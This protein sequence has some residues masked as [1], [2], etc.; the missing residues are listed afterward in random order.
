MKALLLLVLIVLPFSAR[1]QTF[2][3]GGT[4]IFDFQTT[5]STINVLL[6]QTTINMTNFGLET[7]CLNINHTWLADLTIELVAPDGTT[8][9]LASGVGGSDDFMTNTCFNTSASQSILVVTSPFTGTYKPTGSMGL[10]N[11]GQNPNGN[12][13]MKI[14]DSY[15]ADEGNLLNWSLTFGSSPAT[16]MTVTSSNLPIVVINTN[17]VNIPDEPK[18]DGIMGIIN[19]GPGNLNNINDPYNEFYG[20][21]AIEQRGSSSGSFPQRSYGLETR[22]PDPTINYNVSLFDWPSDNDWILYAP[23]TDKSMIRNMLTY[24]IGNATGRWAPRTQLCEVSINGEYVGVYVLMERIKQNPGR[25]DIDELLPEDVADNELSGGYIV[26]I[27]KLTGGGVIAWNSPYPA[28]APS[29]ATIGYQMHDPELSELQTVQFNYI[30]NKI[31]Q[32]E[33]NLSGPNFSDPLTGYAS[34]IDVQSFI[35]YML[36]NELSKNV[37]GYRLS[38]FLYKQRVSEGGKIVAGPLWDFN[39]TYGNADYCQGWLTTGWEL[40]F[41]SYCGGGWDNPFWWKRLL[42]DPWY[43]TQVNCR[44]QE[45]R[46]GVLSNS[47]LN[48]YIDSLANVLAS[49]ATRHYEKWPILGVYVWPNS[50]VGNTYQEEIDFLKSWINDRLIWMDANMFG[51]CQGLSIEEQQI[52]INVYPIPTKEKLT[53]EWS[54]DTEIVDVRLFDSKG[55]YITVRSEINDRSMILDVLG[56][57]PGIYILDLKLANGK[58]LKKKLIIE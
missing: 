45:L 46:N 42:Q 28:S 12:W 56:L 14:T 25:V 55:A 6:P 10:V 58:S 27:D 22:G 19:N 3:G 50:F 5:T 54:E 7:V 21:I 48:A 34:Y 29:T 40:D 35:D 24:H 44:W 52:G 18:I 9:Q 4:P 26:K 41:N 20:E 36:I 11:N 8:F 51:S 37:D 32:W 38:A 43:A 15:G 39:L 31:T 47:S 16:V 33:A 53:I 49:P 13:T 57:D 17:G 30:R 2:S 23:Y 1:L